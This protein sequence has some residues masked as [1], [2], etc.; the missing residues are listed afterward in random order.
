MYRVTIL[1]YG[2]GYQAYC[3]THIKQTYTLYAL[4]FKLHD[5]ITIL[6]LCI[7]SHVSV[8]Q[9]QIGNM[10]DTDKL[11]AVPYLQKT[12]RYEIMLGVGLG[13][14]LMLG[15]GLGSVL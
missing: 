8:V 14:V 11:T 4:F 2:F 3:V 1:M 9:Y 6:L 13:S 15:V 7:V 5:M 12:I 10:G